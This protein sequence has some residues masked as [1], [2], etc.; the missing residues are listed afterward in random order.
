MKKAHNLLKRTGSGLVPSGQ[1]PTGVWGAV[2]ARED[3][4]KSD[5]VAIVELLEEQL[6]E[7]DKKLLSLQKKLDAAKT[8]PPPE[9]APAPAPPP[10]P[11]PAPL[12]PVQHPE[13]IPIHPAATADS[14]GRHLSQFCHGGTAMISRLG[15]SQAV[16]ALPETD[17]AK[18]ME[19]KI[20][21]LYDG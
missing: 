1:K 6:A 13:E 15:L 21:R 3:L 12:P 20:L 14:L 4:S 18:R 19:L 5:A 2:V 7:R 9:P 8:A 11:A 17:H 16:R 10:P